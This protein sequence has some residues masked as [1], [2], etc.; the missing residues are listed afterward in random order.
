M[1]PWVTLGG[2]W[3]AKREA[4]EAPATNLQ[5]PESAEMVRGGCEEG[6]RTVQG[7]SVG[8]KLSPGHSL[9][10]KRYKQTTMDKI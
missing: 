3:G 5:G 2:S 7:T 8:D 10:R 9:S 4:K 6:A 1:A